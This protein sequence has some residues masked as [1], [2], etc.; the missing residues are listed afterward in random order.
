MLPIETPF[1]GFCVGHEP[2]V[3]PLWPG[4][5]FVCEH[6]C[7]VPGEWVYPDAFPDLLPGE[8]ASE[9][10]ALFAVRRRL[11]QERFAG[12]VVLTQYRKLVARRPVG[13]AAEAGAL[14]F[15]LLAPDDAGGLC[16]DD[17]LPRPGQDWLM[18]A[19]TRLPVTVGRHYAHSHVGR[20]LLR[21]L[22]DAI[23]AGAITD[24]EAFT[25][26][27]TKRNVFSATLGAYPAAAFI[28]IFTRLE[29]AAIAFAEGGYVPRHDYQRRVIGFCLERLHG[30]LVS[31]AIVRSEAD[32]TQV[33]GY[34][35]LVSAD[36][37]YVPTR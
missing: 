9:Y 24:R 37:G 23:D 11:E 20:D 30:I 8:A 33:R 36:Q 34:L 2:P 31:A 32:G 18:S 25:V 17:A 22:A 27:G 14:Q 35:T 15:Q 28:K 12:T 19:P 10:P 13:R 29:Q 6:A 26:I 1:R 7:G 5:T 4:F 3:V 16:F 21:F